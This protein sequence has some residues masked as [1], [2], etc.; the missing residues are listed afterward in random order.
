MGRSTPIVRVPTGSLTCRLHRLVTSAQPPLKSIQPEE[1]GP[2]EWDP[3]GLLPPPPSGGHFARRGELSDAAEQPAAAAAPPA[4]PVCD[5]LAP[6]KRK[7]P[8]IGASAPLTAP[9]PPVTP[10]QRAFGEVP[11]APET[12]LS[13]KI[14]A[15]FL[16]TFWGASAAPRVLD[17]FRRLCLGEEFVKVWPG[18]GVQRAGSYVAGLS[19]VPFPDVHSGAYPWLEEVE[20]QAAVIQEEF[21]AAMAAPESLQSKGNRVWVAAAR[22]DAVEYGPNWR[23]LVLQDRGIWETTNSALFPRTTQILKDL[24]GEATRRAKLIMHH[25]LLCT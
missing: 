24:N 15:A 22:E 9:S 25:V 10:P 23:T 6:R 3:E 1:T 4:A 21:K 12:S 18:L 17:S 2:T 14:E 19:A 16:E 7:T 5:L 11:A 20:R 8:V 13:G